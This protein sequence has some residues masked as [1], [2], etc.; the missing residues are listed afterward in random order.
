M[1][2]EN[3]KVKTKYCHNSGPVLES[4]REARRLRMGRARRATDGCPVEGAREGSKAQ[5][6]TMLAAD[7]PTAARMGGWYPHC[8]RKP[9]MAGPMRKPMLKATPMAP[10]PLARSFGVVTSEI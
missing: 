3:M 8:A 7:R 6:A 5:V 10:N 9:E 4:R 1:N 2:I